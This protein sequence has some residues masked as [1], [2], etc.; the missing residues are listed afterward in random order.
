MSYSLLEPCVYLALPDADALMLA[1]GPVFLDP[2]GPAVETEGM[3][4]D[5]ISCD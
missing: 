2:V 5:D 1:D 3:G 4:F